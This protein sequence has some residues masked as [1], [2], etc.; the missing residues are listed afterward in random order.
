MTSLQAG[1]F[2]FLVFFFLL[3]QIHFGSTDF[4]KF[5]KSSYNNKQ[6]PGKIQ[7][8]YFPIR[9]LVGKLYYYQ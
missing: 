1:F 6:N 4:Q 8:K 9:Q 2:A 3:A 7:Q 5:S